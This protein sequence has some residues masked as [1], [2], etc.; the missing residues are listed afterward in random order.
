MRRVK[1]LTLFL[2]LAV[3]CSSCAGEGKETERKL[4]LVESIMRMYPDSS[5]SIITNIGS[6][7][8]RS[9]KIRARH[10][11][12][13][14]MALDKCGTDIC[15]DSII[16]PAVEY[17]SRQGNDLEQAQTYYYKARIHENAGSDETAMIWLVRAEAKSEKTDDAYLRSL[18]RAAKGRIYFRTMDYTASAVNYRKAAA[19]C[20]MIEDR[21]RHTTNKL[22]EADCLIMMKQYGQA[23]DIIESLRSY[24]GNLSIR[25]LNR[26]HQVIIKLAESSSLYDINKARE[27]YLSVTYDINLTDWVLIAGTY[28][29]EGD[30]VKAMAALQNEQMIIESGSYQYRLAQTYGLMGHYKEAFDAFMNYD[31]TSGEIGRGILEQDTRFIEERELRKEQYEKERMK[32]MIMLL[33]VC[34]GIAGLVIALMVIFMI[35][36]DLKLKEAENRSLRKQFDELLQERDELSRAET[37]NIEARKIISERLKIIDHFVMSEALNDSFFEKKASE[38][39]NSIIADRKE[40]IRQTRLIFSASY[41][42]FI[43]YLVEKGLDETEIELCCLYAIGMNGKMITSF[44][45]VKRH[46]HIGSDIRKKFGLSG[47]DTNLSIHI[48]NVM[49]ETE[50]L[51]TK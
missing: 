4:D 32:G 33:A 16:S 50:G 46:Y 29:A 31:K 30:A 26:F 13:H 5:L 11:L 8:I 7:R 37:N 2:I 15:S 49:R 48:R 25:N 44:T 20:M 35:R 18:I 43:G 34:L 27:D 1:S 28:L 19:D 23:R 17:Y 36:K 45:N 40:F 47:H 39:L 3:F 24:I 21:E 14:S 10:S 51:Q 9:R 12:L 6:E 22:R 38:T 41:P 42:G